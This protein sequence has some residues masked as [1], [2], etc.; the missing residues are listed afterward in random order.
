[1]SHITSIG[2][3]LFSDLSIAE[4]TANLTAAEIAAL[5][6]SAEFQALFATEIASVG[7]TKAANTFIRVKN[8]REFPPLGTPPNI[9]NVPVYGQ[10]TSQ[11]IQAQADAPTFEVTL[12][13]VPAEWADSTLLGEMVGDGVVRVFRFTLMNSEPTGTG[14][15]KYASTA[16]GIGT[17]PNTQFYFAGKVEALQVTPSLSDSGT[18]TVTFSVQTAFFGSFTI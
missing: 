2:A 3:N 10:K 13:F 5:D 1:M 18:A 4:A 14:A 16:P 12:N 11:Q 8:A 15:T 9:V 7:G 6:T 17:V